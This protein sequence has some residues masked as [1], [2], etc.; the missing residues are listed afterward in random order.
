[1]LFIRK[2][3]QI[4]RADLRAYLIINAVVYGLL[5]GGFLTA[6]IFPDVGANR[7]ATLEDDGTYDLVRSLVNNPWLSALIIFGVNVIKTAALFI[8]LPSLV[9]PFSGIVLFAY[10]IFNIGLGL[11]PTSDIVAVGLIPHS[12]TALIEFQAYAL[13]MF[14]AYVFGRSWVLPATVGARNHR[15]GYVLGLKQ[16]GWLSVP[17][18][19]LFVVG[20]V[21][22]AFS[23]RYL[24]SPLSQWLR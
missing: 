5:I 15:Q 24:I 14:G 4:I 1:M 9:V 12:L 6:L 7:V 11:A 3:I 2:P 20:A 8:V 10:Q 21:W 17:A 18:L 22:E 16:L 23:I 19:A 13:L